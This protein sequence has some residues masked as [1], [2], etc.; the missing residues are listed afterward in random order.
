MR[1]HL[2]N[3][4][5]PSPNLYPIH[6]GP[7]SMILHLNF[8]SAGGTKR[9]GQKVGAAKVSGTPE[10]GPVFSTRC[11]TIPA[12]SAVITL[13]WVFIKDCVFSLK[14]CD[15]SALCQFCCSAGFLP[16][17][18]VYTHWHRGKTEKGQSPKNSDKNTIF[19]EHP[20]LYPMTPEKKPAFGYLVRGKNHRPS[21]RGS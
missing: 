3:R 8:L 14:C 11:L 6:L 20:V 18:Y 10:V 13:Y 15:F 5:I 1:E 19:N 7:C 21:V 12:K 16:A 2:Y 9:G 17:W 4:P